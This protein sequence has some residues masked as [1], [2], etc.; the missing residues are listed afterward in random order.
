MSYTL[1]MTFLHKIR[2]YM[3]PVYCLINVCHSLLS[4][5]L[6]NFSL[7]YYLFPTVFQGFNTK[8]MSFILALK[9]ASL[10]TKQHTHLL[11]NVLSPLP[12]PHL[13]FFL[14]KIQV[15]EELYALPGDQ[16]TVID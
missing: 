14:F 16:V 2:M 9:S 13:F 1:L 8:M 12:P 4:M 6:L 3:D 5:G 11:S 10:K 7:S 15:I